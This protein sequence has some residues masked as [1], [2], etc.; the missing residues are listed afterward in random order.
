MFTDTNDGW[1]AD[2]GDYNNFLSDKQTYKARIKYESP[3]N[4]PN[5]LTQ[6]AY[7]GKGP[8]FT[9][10]ERE[11]DEK[12]VISTLTTSVVCKTSTIM[13][14]NL[15]PIFVQFDED[16]VWSMTKYHLEIQ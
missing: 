9:H 12:Y 1:K 2:D 11:I 3:Q 8:V 7:I 15:T 13:T 4:E 16:M 6:L 14:K 10:L 5:A